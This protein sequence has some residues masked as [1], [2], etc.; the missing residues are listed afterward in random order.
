MHPS[1]AIYC[2]KSEKLEGKTIVMG[3]TGSI[4][5]TECVKLIRELVR[6][7]AKV[8]PVMSEWG[9]KIIHPN[10]LEFAS[11]QKPIIQIDGSV[12]YVDICGE[13][14][15]ADL[16]LIAPATANTIAKIAHG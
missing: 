4:A 12:Q 15:Y 1:E 14:G 13:N 2:Q 11:G 8:I 9:Q 3:V 10:S 5:A 16:M 6:H 7:G